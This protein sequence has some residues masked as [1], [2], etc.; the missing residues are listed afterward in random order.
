MIVEEHKDLSALSAMRDEWHVLAAA[1]DHDLPYLLPEFLLPWLSRLGDR[2]RICFL[3]AR[4]VDGALVGLAPLVSRR[5]TFMGIS[6]DMLQFPEAWPSPPCD[7]LI[8]PKHKGVAEAL[9]QHC[10]DQMQWD[11]C[12]LLNVPAE[13]NLGNYFEQTVQ[14][15]GYSVTRE[16]SL[17]TYHVPIDTSWDD[18]FAARTKKFRQNLR[19]GLRFCEGIGTVT[20]KRYPGDMSL[21]EVSAHVQAL[22]PNSWK[23]GETDD[24]DWGT[25]LLELIGRFAES[26]RARIDFMLLD[27]N[28]IAYLFSTPYTHKVFALHNAYH[29]GYQHGNLGQY[30]LMRA[31][32][33]A[34]DAGAECYD[35]TGNKPYLRQWTK[36]TRT[37][38]R[39]VVARPSWFGRLRYRAYQQLHHARVEKVDEH[40]NSV[41]ERL[42][43]RHRPN[44]K[45][46]G[47][48]DVW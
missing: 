45:T 23:G 35:F 8:H 20:F 37:F 48:G 5:I 18:F 14:S 21:E 39:I 43:E 30:M 15:Q 16:Q 12:E 11:V 28:A 42:K 2:Y 47:R 36:V 13:S 33:E 22:L 9:F 44:T 1:C 4:S 29:L 6:L 34:F 46:K 38:E 32:H 40:T 31:L 25:F 26:G 24:G 19:R 7:W 3:S 27:D 10:A 41:K 17:E